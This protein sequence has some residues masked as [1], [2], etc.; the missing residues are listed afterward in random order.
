MLE[1][2]P[3]LVVPQ[4][5]HPGSAELLFVEDG[6]GVLEVGDRRVAV[7][8]GVALYVPEGVLHRYEGDG[9]RPLRAIQV[10]SPSGPEQRF[11]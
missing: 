10:Y 8:P 3:D 1:G 4:H 7:R 6:S 11:R 9:S 5:R 2:T